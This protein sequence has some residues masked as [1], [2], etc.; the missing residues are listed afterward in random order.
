MQEIAE[1]VMPKLSEHSNNI[2]LNEALFAR[3]KQVY[4]NTNKE[5][6][7]TEDRMLLQTTYDG[8]IRSGANLMP[9]QKERFRQLSSELSLLTLRFSQNNLKETNNYE[10]PLQ[11][12]QL[13]GLPESALNAYAETAKEKGKEGYIV[14][15]PNRY[16]TLG[17]IT[18]SAPSPSQ[19]L[20]RA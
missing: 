5:S 3:I 13:A 4:D 9:E 20:S 10:L 15:F 8:F 2:T 1:R 11:E 17:S 16:F 12:D 18:V 14:T 19:R 7:D 6:L